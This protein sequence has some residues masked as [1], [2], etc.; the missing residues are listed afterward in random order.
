VSSTTG[1]SV[2]DLA[3]GAADTDLL[4]VDGRPCQAVLVV[5]LDRTPSPTAIDELQAGRRAREGDRLLLGRTSRKVSDCPQALLDALDLTLVR[6]PRDQLCAADA[7]GP[8]A[9]IAVEDPAAE[10]ELLRGHGEEQPQAALVLRQLLQLARRL[11][12][13]QALDAESLAYS[14]LL[15]G[16]GFA[17]WLR[18]RGPRPVPPPVAADPVIVRRVGDIL[19]ITLNRAERRNAYG[20]ELRD[21]LAAAVD[22]AVWDTSIREVVLDG[23]GPCFSSGGDL[24]EFGTAPDLATAHLI[25]TRAGVARRFV[26]VSGRLTARLHGHCIGA[27]IELPAFASRVVAASDT[28]VR[29]PELAMGLI[30]GAGG[31]VS[32]TRRIGRWRT[33]YLVL[34]GRS[35]AV[36]RALAWGLVDRVEP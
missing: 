15:G 17:R 23:N 4:D 24:D 22:Q 7:A 35:V 11:P 8:P 26:A 32:V 34:D 16:P 18:A 33:L 5:D 25:R 9:T 19:R 27:G 2:A 31:T 29:L 20:A 13:P 30:P 6:V 21:A 28:H 3:A 1:I 14:T 12:V 10:A 36:E